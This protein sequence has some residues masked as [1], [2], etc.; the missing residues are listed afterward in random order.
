MGAARTPDPHIWPAVLRLRAERKDLLVGALSNTVPFPPDHELAR[1]PDMSAPPDAA[2][3]ADE[4]TIVAK[5]KAGEGSGQGAEDGSVAGNGRDLA[6]YFDVFVASA[7]EGLRKPE[8][9]IYELAVRRLDASDRRRGGDGVSAA[10]VVFLDDIGANLKPARE[11]G[12]QTV[13]VRI[14]DTA[15]AVRELERIIGGW[16]SEGKGR[17]SGNGAG[18]KL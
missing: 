11:M 9:R 12:M 10:E 14:D 7:R 13:L 6:A 8:P 2:A 4:R 3:A 15:A 18:A 17:A 5:E 1:G 16:K